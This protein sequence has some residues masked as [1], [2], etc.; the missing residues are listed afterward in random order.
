MSPYS[1]RSVVFEDRAR[2]ALPTE[3][4]S[5][6]SASVWRRSPTSAQLGTLLGNPPR[7]TSDVFEVG[8]NFLQ[9][10]NK[11]SAFASTQASDCHFRELSHLALQELMDAAALPAWRKGDTPPVLGSGSRFE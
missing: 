5:R 10:G 1:K 9:Q 8:P 6:H 3:R 7:W 2:P 4:A 11:L